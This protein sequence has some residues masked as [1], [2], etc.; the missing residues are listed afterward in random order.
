[1]VRKTPTRLQHPSWPLRT[2]HPRPLRR[3]RLTLLFAVS[4]L[5]GG[6]LGCSG[7]TAGTAP[8]LAQTQIY[9]ALRFNYHAVNMATTAPYNTV[10]LTA[11][12]VNAAESPLLSLGPVTYTAAD[13]AVTVSQTGL[14]TARYTTPSTFVTATLH[15]QRSNVTH[16]DTVFIQVTDTVPQSPLA[17][18]SIQPATA[19][20]AK[21]AQDDGSFAWP[22]KVI[23]AAGDTVCNDELSTCPLLVSFTISDPTIATLYGRPSSVVQPRQP[24]HVTF[25]A[26]T[27]AYG[28]AK[29]DSLQFV[30][31]YQI[32]PTIQI[33]SATPVASLTPVLSFRPSVAIVGVGADVA[34]SFLTQNGPATSGDSIDVVFDT[35][36]AAQPG[37]GTFFGVIY[38]NVFPSTG[39]G[40]IPSFAPD[41]A[42]Y[43]AYLS[44]G[45][46]LKYFQ[47][48]PT[49]VRARTFPAAGTYTYHSR[50]YGTKGTIIVAAGP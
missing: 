25:Y 32:V 46:I 35:P 2:G 23:N 3:R 17:A 10:Q 37:C 15:D 38:C 14:V 18:L 7:D 5:G 4:A 12:P 26:T 28:V 48:L 40:N 11:T 34:W 21:R 16:T 22:I 9:W 24:G 19:D 49:A 31:G 1:M 41:T 39:G 29:T 44:T 43:T 33:V 45:D 36:G 13:S 30:I 27:Y 6:A 42:A 47:Y 8:V 50:R 20:S